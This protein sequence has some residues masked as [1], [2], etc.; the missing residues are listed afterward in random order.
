[1]TNYVR[2]YKKS[3][4]LRRLS[5]LL[6]QNLRDKDFRGEAG[7]IF[8]FVQNDIR[9][10]LDI[11][12]VETLQ[13]PIVTLENRAGDCD[14]KSTLLAAMLESIGHKTRFVAAGFGGRDIEHVFVETRIGQ[15]WIACDATEPYPMGWEP[16]GITIRRYSHN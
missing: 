4:E 16:P 13:T 5:N 1:M 12:D 10:L 11:A 9:Y 8:D 7:L 6:T 15:D 2:E 3:P 14:D